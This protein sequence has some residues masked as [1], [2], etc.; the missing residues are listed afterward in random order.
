M[1]VWQDPVP[2]RTASTDGGILSPHSQ[3]R[4]WRRPFIILK[5]DEA[6]RGKY[7]TIFL[8][9]CVR[10]GFAFITPNGKMTD[11]SAESDRDCKIIVFKSGP[12]RPHQQHFLMYPSIPKVRPL[13]R[14]SRITIWK[15]W[16]FEI[17]R[18]WKFRLVYLERTSRAVGFTSSGL[19]FQ[20][21]WKLC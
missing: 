14:I 17:C 2:A 12:F 13:S 8:I 16:I 5:V 3:R 19:L 10:R 4:S 11:K 1:Q 7:Q 20:H 18:V 9:E 15:C 6:Q 21:D